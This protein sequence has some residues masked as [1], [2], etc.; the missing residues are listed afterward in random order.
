MINLKCSIFYAM[1]LFCLSLTAMRQA[2]GHYTGNGGASRAITNLGFQPE[3]VLVKPATASTSFIATSTMTAG[4]AKIL[5]SA[6]V[7]AAN[8]VNS[9]DADGFT[10]G[11]SANA[12][13]VIY[14]FVAL[15]NADGDITVGTYTGSTSS[16]TINLG[17]RPAMLWVLGEAGDWNDY[18]NISMDGWDN[19]PDAFSSA[20]TLDASSASVSS[21]TASGFTVPASGSSGVDDG[22]KYNYVAFKNSSVYTGTYTGNGTSESVNIG[23]TSDWVIVKDVTDLNNNLWFKNYDM[24]ATTSYTFINGPSTIAINGISSTGFSLGGQGE[25]NT[26]GHTMQYFSFGTATGTLPVELLS[27]T[28]GKEGGVVDLFWQTASEVNSDYYLIERSADGNYPEII[29][30]IPAAGSSYTV[31]NYS[32]TDKNPLPQNNYYRLKSVDKD[33]SCAVSRTIAIDF[34]GNETNKI[35]LYPNPVYDLLELKTDDLSGKI[36]MLNTNG[37]LQFEINIQNFN[38]QIDV[39]ELPQGIYLMEFIS[40]NNFQ[41]V[42]FVKE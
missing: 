30:Q 36:R 34:T 16:Q 3:A 15:D 20:S 31:L 21:Y 35:S 5:S 10:A 33:G 14:Y 41:T 23:A 11:S 42:K 18:G 28:G 8:Y 27:F 32:F 17:Y 29:G 26:S 38:T 39:H 40:K 9:F 2:V 19:I 25:V 22:S 12:N 24:P 4:R 6:N 1:M 13:G 37:Q 7:P